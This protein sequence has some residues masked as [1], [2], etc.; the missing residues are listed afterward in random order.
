M[1]DFKPVDVNYESRIEQNYEKLV[2]TML[3]TMMTVVK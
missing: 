3:S 2:A 1:P